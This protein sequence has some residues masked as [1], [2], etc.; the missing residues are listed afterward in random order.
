MAKRPKVIM[1]SQ[2]RK[3]GAMNNEETLVGS[4]SS[5]QPIAETAQAVETGAAKAPEFAKA[6]RAKRND[7]REVALDTLAPGM[8]FKGKVRNVVEFGAFVDIGVGRDG[9]VH[10]SI[11]KR[12]GIDKTLK[13]G[14]AIDVVIRRIDVEDNRISLTLPS[15][16]ST[17]KTALRD[18]KLNAVVTGH[19]VRLADFGAFVDIGAQ[20]DGLLHVSQ[21]PWGYVNHPSEVMKV[22]DEVQVRILEVDP[23]KRRISLTMKEPEAHVEE[24][25]ASVKESEPAERLPSVFEAAFQKAHQ[26]RAR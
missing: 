11:L 25:K 19:V 12:A 7:T 16:E 14:D 5:A 21:L 23:R 10:I 4:E 20:A 17:E 22:G 26:R 18:L 13:V 1:S 9:L 3:S 6:V 2:V 15:A 8:P 24:V